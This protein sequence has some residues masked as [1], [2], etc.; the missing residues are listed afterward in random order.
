MMKINQRDKAKRMVSL[1]LLIFLGQLLIPRFSWEA[2]V[3]EEMNP[4]NKEIIKKLAAFLPPSIEGWKPVEEDSLYDPETIFS[5]INGAGEVY[6]SYNFRW[7]LVRRY[8]KENSPAIIV[9]FFELERSEDAFGLFTHDL[10]GE[11][12]PIGQDALYK[13]GWLAFWKDRFYVSIYAEAETEEAK[14]VILKLGEQVARAIPGEGQR[15]QLLN[16]LPTSWVTNEVRYFHT[17]PILNYHFFVSSENWLELDESTE[18]L[19]AY[20]LAEGQRKTY[21]LLIKY[22][23]EDKAKKAIQQF[24]QNYLPEA[25]DSGVA[26]TENGLWDGAKVYQNFGLLVFAAGSLEE[27]EGIIKEVIGKIEEGKKEG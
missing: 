19:L 14:K 13:S 1:I 8:E 22:P 24:L 7:L 6:R 20:R 25:D 4:M 26:P 10:E 23:D 16:Y 12:V 15:P 2:T 9:D 18:A 21:L 11:R 3:K 27:I 17:L 5:Y